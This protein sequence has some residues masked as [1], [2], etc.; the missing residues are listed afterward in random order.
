MTFGSHLKTVLS[1]YIS[2]IMLAM[3]LYRRELVINKM[4][5]EDVSWLLQFQIVLGYIVN[6]AFIPSFRGN[7]EFF[8]R[9]N[10]KRVNFLKRVIAILT[11]KLHFHFCQDY[12]QRPSEQLLDHISVSCAFKIQSSS[13]LHILISSKILKQFISIMNSASTPSVTSIPFTPYLF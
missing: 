3:R 11:L 8:L 2:F 10:F 13:R 4:P 5:D 12:L 7:C 1:A 6:E 9:T